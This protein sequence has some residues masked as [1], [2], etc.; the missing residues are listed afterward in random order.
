MMPH[1]RILRKFT[2]GYKLYKL[3]ENLNHIMYI[4]DMKLF[5]QNEKFETL[6]QSERIYC[7]DIGMEFGIEKC[8]MLIIRNR[9]QQ[10]I[11]GT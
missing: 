10:V 3:Q 5:A 8:A 11:E 4:D 6:Q 7:E 1:I 2:S 9:K